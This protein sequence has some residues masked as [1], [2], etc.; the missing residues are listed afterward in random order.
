MVNML[1]VVALF[2]LIGAAAATG[3]AYFI[4]NPYRLIVLKRRMTGKNYGI[5]Q[6]VTKGQAM[7]PVTK[8]F[9][10]DIIRAKK[11]IWF[12][13][14][15][16]IYKQVSAEGKGGLTKRQ[17]ETELI[18][19]MVI[20]SEEET[21]QGIAPMMIETRERG[22]FGLPSRQNYYET[23]V[24]QHYTFKPEDIQF[25]SGVPMVFLDVDDMLPLKLKSEELVNEPK[26]RNPYQIEAVLGKE[27]AAA[28]LEA[29]KMTKKNIQL[30]LIV[31]CVLVIISI[32]VGFLTWDNTNKIG[33]MI[34]NLT[35]R[36]PDVVSG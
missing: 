16:K 25:R 19:D 15:G 17:A 8:N 36:V 32:I 31:A 14:A 33:G 23:K 28:E 9:D 35:Q 2:M 13:Q 5:V 22:R 30:L 6:F 4:F 10:K 21:A 34:Y 1:E 7:F 3:F 11:G 29:I 26:S 18:K 12:F 24:V 20:S 27:V